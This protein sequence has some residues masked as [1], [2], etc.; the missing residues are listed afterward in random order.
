M[1]LY[2]SSRSGWSGGYWWVWWQDRWLW[3]V[4]Y[5]KRGLG[6]PD[7]WGTVTR[8]CFTFRQRTL[9][10]I[11][12]CRTTNKVKPQELLSTVFYARLTVGQMTFFAATC[13]RITNIIRKLTMSHN[14]HRSPDKSCRR[15]T[16][17]V[18]QWTL[19]YDVNCRHYKK[20]DII[21]QLLLSGN[22]LCRRTNMIWQ[23][24]LSDNQNCPETD[25]IRKM[26]FALSDKE[27]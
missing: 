24:K 6:P 14:G 2:C 12:L 26:N 11:E 5:E 15:V 18:G 1:A 4:W 27:N 23:W 19:F 7:I 20:N 22:W 10:D 16:D 25:S 13:C 9:L 17:N 21:R 3:R 8:A